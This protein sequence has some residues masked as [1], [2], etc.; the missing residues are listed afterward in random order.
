MRERV[1]RRG[2]EPAEGTF[3]EYFD[4]DG[5][6]RPALEQ[7]M[8]ALTGASDAEMQLRQRRA[9]DAFRTGGVTFSVYSDSAGVEKI[10]PF[11]L[12][13]RPIVRSDWETMEAGLKQRSV[14]LNLFIADVYG[15]QQC[16]ED[17]VIP[18]ELV[19]GGSGYLPAIKG[20]KPPHDVYTHI[21]GIDL[22]RDA[23][24]EFVVLEDNLRCPSGVS[25]VLENR[26]IMKRVFPRAF[27]NVSVATVEEYPH[28]LRKAFHQLAPRNGD[29]GLAVILTPGAFNSAY[30]EHSFLARRTGM[31]LVQGQDLFVDDDV[32]YAH[33]TTGPKR[34]DVIYRRIDDAF[35]D[36]KVFREDSMLGV[37]GIIDAWAAGNVTICNAPGA[38]VADDKAVY[39]YVPDL[40]RYYLD[41]DPILKQVETWVCDREKELEHVLQNMSRFVV[42]AVDGAGGYGMHFGPTSTKA[43]Q[44]EFAEKLRAN[45]RGYIA[46]PLVEFS[47]C[48]IWSNGAMVPRRVDLRPFLIM[49][50]EPWVMPGGLTRVAL[51]EGSYVVN[52]SQGGGSK[53]TWIVGD[54]E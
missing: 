42:K 18:K 3:D 17:K 28:Q 39:S 19:L 6:P 25:Y 12:L 46:Q 33:T 15:E 40:I 10:F 26:S 4:A 31:P 35:L 14:A 32:V 49:T 51:K 43:E 38:G 9:D 23:N 5:T 11:D 22:L 53:D 34:V 45:P 13:P 29:G 44:E 48:P 47:T 20:I 36:P 54:D 21:A 30:F 27:D 2:Y 7:V 8:L 37:A 1:N 24:G 50:P 52:S 16:F 41:A